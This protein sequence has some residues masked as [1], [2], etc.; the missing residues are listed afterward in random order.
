MGDEAVVGNYSAEGLAGAV[1]EKAAA[2]AG[3]A[4]LGVEHL[5]LFD[6]LHMG[7][8][9]A[10]AQVAEALTVGHGGRVLDVGSGMGGPARSVAT[11]LG[12]HV[13]GVDLTPVHVEAAQTLS[14]RVGLSGITTFQVGDATDLT[15]ED[16]TFDAAMMLFVGMNVPAKAAVFSEV[17][18][19]LVPSGTFVVYDPM[20]TGPAQ[21]DF[22]VPW[23][24]GPDASFLATVEEYRS[25]LTEAGFTV[26]EEH[27]LA[28]LVEQLRQRQTEGEVAGQQEMMSAWFDSEGP[29]RFRNIASAIREGVVEPRLMVARRR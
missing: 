18:R 7:G 5:A 25:L 14:D 1:L 10:T 9:L 4:P 23:A 20:R 19:V 12:P 13:T 26:E 16:A 28:G 6:E 3:S 17:H 27:N 2:V 29:V 15:F 24:A 8:R 22:P 11:R 21:P